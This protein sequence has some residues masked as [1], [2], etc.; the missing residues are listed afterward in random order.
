MAEAKKKKKIKL[1]FSQQHH[2][3]TF[4]NT[5]WNDN[6]ICRM[7]LGICST[8]AVTNRLNNAVAMGLGVTFAMAVSSVSI[9]AIRNIV[10]R[11]VRMIV[12]MIVIS[13]AVI[14]VDRY[15]KAFFPDISEAMGPYV[16][17]IITNCIIMGRAESFASI[18]KPLDSLVDALGA[19]TGY[20]F[21]LL[22]IAAVREL[23]GFGTLFNIDIMG[24]DWTNWVIM[25][26]APG[27]FLVLGVFIWVLRSIQQSYDENP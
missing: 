1:K 18:N 8:L 4:L 16:G 6:P 11:R 24:P 17:L 12:Y 10:P 5:L 27:A 20:M 23:L 22:V 14:V 15:L 13:T 7:V 19:G 21:A 9:S 25:I 26:M 2:V 3:K